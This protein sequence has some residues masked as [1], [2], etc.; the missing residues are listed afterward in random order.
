[1]SS[2]TSKVPPRKP[3]SLSI[4][5]TREMRELAVECLREFQRLCWL[6]VDELTTGMIPIESYLP[7]PLIETLIDSLPTFYTRSMLQ[8]VVHNGEINYRASCTIMVPFTTQSTYV[9][10]CSHELIQILIDLHTQFD[11]IRTRKREEVKAR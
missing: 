10:D 6:D 5:V 9:S 11:G 3:L 1:M 2:A 7:D 8:S 4:W